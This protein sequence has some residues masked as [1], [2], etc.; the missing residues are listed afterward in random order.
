MALT[1]KV[2][3]VTVPA[4]TGGTLT[5]ASITGLTPTILG[6]Y[7]LIEHNKAK[8]IAMAKEARD[9]GVIGK[10]LRDLLLSRITEIDKK[11]LRTSALP[12]NQSVILPYV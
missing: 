3:I 6:N 7:N 10:P 8:V 12:G 5:S 1:D 4:G 2:R 9:I 11:S